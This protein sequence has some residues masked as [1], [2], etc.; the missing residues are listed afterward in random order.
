MSKKISR[1]AYADMYGITTGDKLTLGDTNLQ[2]CIEKDY[3]V[4][5]EECKFGGGKV[6]RDGMGQATG[7]NQE[8]ALDLIFYQCGY[9]RLHRYLQS[10]YW[11]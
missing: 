11:C 10:R 3:T 2:I 6:L 7:I 1:D 4:Y 5:G 8:D 9:Y